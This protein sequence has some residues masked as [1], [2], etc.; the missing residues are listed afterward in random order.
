MSVVI[1]FEDAGPCRKQLTIEVPAPAVEA[2]MGRVVADYRQKVSIPGFRKG[3][4]PQGLIQQR[5]RSDI[6]KEVADRLIPRYWQQAQA[7][8]SL[9]PLLPPQVEDL[10]LKSGE[11]LTFVASVEIRPRIELKDYRAFDLP[12]GKTEATQEEVDGAIDGLRRQQGTWVPVERA[13]ARGDLVTGQ[14]RRLPG[15]E[16]AAESVAETAAGDEE[17]GAEEN[18]SF[19]IE[20]GGDGVSE[21]MNLALTGALAG[22]S[23]KLSQ[24]A[25]EGEDKQTLHFDLDIIAVK[26]KELPEIDEEFVGQVSPFK[27]VD[28]L[29]KAVSEQLSTSKRGELHQ[30][31]R[32]EVM[33][34]LIER[35]PFDLPVGVVEQE[36][37]SMM[38]EY[39]ENLMQQGVD[40]EK[41]PMDW[42]RMAVD[43]KPQAE[44]RVHGRLIL[45]AIAE[46]DELKIDEK[47][48]EA[49][50][51][52]LAA[53]QGQSAFVLRQQLSDSGRLEDL[54]SQVLREHTLKHLLGELPAGDEAGET[55]E[56]SAEDGDSASD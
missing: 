22:R 51:G 48:F 46:A 35:H 26:E 6:E 7:E 1:A 38:R 45:D 10:K 13:A 34:K 5:F 12:E 15:D 32:K 11:A 52:Q 39:A 33:E 20:V 29:L 16:P 2:E 49:L 30:N 40:L 53:A 18:R 36:V 50:L 25:G 14:M 37:E 24:E 44:R 47:E 23:A 55:E 8:K 31:R 43:I 41:M 9:E 27:T 28:E 42:E 3:K 19:E 21:E 54:R 4:V 56:A 17:E